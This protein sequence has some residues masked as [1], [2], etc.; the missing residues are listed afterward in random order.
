MCAR[1]LSRPAL[2]WDTAELKPRTWKVTL[3]PIVQMQA[4]GSDEIIVMSSVTFLN[5]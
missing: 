1:V 2:G 4:K 3:S 5:R